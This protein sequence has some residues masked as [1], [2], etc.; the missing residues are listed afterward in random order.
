MDKIILIAFSLHPKY[1]SEAGYANRWLEIM[2]DYYQVDVFTDSESRAALSNK[3]YKNVQ[4]HF[5]E[6]INKWKKFGVRTGLVHIATGIFFKKVKKEL[7]KVDIRE[8]SLIHCI[9]P[10]GI[11][12][13]NDLYKLGLP[14][15]VGPLGGGLP[16]PR[17]F[18]QAFRH[19]RIKTF[20][21]DLFYWYHINWNTR[22]RNYLANS[23]RIILGMSTP[24]GILPEM[25]KGKCA[26]IPDALVDTS[27]F[28]PATRNK[29]NGSV[30]ILFAGRL[31]SNK[32]PFLLLDAIKLCIDRGI[33]NFEVEIAGH[34]MLR[35]QIEL[36]IKEQGMH[37]HVKLLG[38]LSK[39]ALLSKYQSSD[40]FCLPTLREPGGIAI[41]EA[42]ACGLPIIT[43]NYGGP[44]I[45]VTDECGIKIQLKD[46]ISYV[47]DLADALI[48]LIKNPAI[49]CAMGSEGRKRV[50]N[51]F[52][53]KSIRT[54]ILNLYDDI[55]KQT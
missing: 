27:Y 11:H 31:I 51:E 13:Y 26:L 20:L 40:I 21:R 5:I 53:V 6:D 38:G 3:N 12:S 14:V 55:I 54:K 2:S 34:G 32:G 37:A 41:L 42:M 39:D 16:T 30:R 18:E 44:S 1:G 33:N 10:A 49:R 7:Q 28:V 19:Q 47:N 15:V 9:T 43:S 29:T 22:F 8:F 23:E 4:F 46:Y 52:S 48:L 24:Q 50:E 36:Q 25:T 35:E 45:S 17:G